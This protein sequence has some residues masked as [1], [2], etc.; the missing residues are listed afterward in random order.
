MKIELLQAPISGFG[1]TRDGQS[2]DLVDTAKMAE[3]AS[4]MKN[5][6]LSEYMKKYPQG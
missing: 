5:D 1:T 6:K 2:I 4:A 3:L